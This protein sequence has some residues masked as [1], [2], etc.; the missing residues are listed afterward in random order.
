MSS[1]RL[2]FLRDPIRARDREPAAPLVPGKLQGHAGS[3]KHFFYG[4]SADR[5]SSRQPHDGV[6][7]HSSLYAR[8]VLCARSQILLGK[9]LSKRNVTRNCN[10]R[11]PSPTHKSQIVL[12]SCWLLTKC[13]HLLEGVEDLQ[14]LSCSH[15]VFLLSR[16][17][18][19]PILFLTFGL[20]IFIEGCFSAVKSL[21][22]D[23]EEGLLTVCWTGGSF[24]SD[25][26]CCRGCTLH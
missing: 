11:R 21:C 25:G 22:C 3:R 5:S 20:N 7:K 6:P 16:I 9:L 17:A 2:P 1:L 10:F 24:Y 8:A 14:E 26:L 23:E 12:L 18:V 19:S 13:S 15:T 4:S